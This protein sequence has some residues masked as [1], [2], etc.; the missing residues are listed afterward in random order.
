MRNSSTRCSP[1]TATALG[2]ALIAAAGCGPAENDESTQVGTARAPLLEEPCPGASAA[3]GDQ[4]RVTAFV[5]YVIGSPTSPFDAYPCN[6]PLSAPV[7][8]LTAPALADLLQT[9][10]AQGLCTTHDPTQTTV[11]GL[12]AVER[13][14]SCTGISAVDG[15]AVNLTASSIDLCWGSGAGAFFQVSESGLLGNILSVQM[16]PEPVL[17]TQIL[18]GS[19]G[20]TASAIYQN[21]SDPTS[22]LKW[23]STYVSAP[24]VSPGTPCSTTD[25]ASGATATMAIVPAGNFR[26]CD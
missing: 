21:S 4:Q 17:T 8:G 20:A 25:L 22:V 12:P 6:G 18:T 23:Y 10:F 5:A 13:V 16:D 15:L 3:V 24:E 11:C 9:L 26:A 14:L 7:G 1:T 2:A 19:N